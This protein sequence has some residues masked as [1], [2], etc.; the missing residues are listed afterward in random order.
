[1]IQLSNSNL[2]IIRNF[3]NYSNVFQGDYE[4]GYNPPLLTTIFYNLNF[5]NIIIII[6]ITII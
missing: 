1:M 5:N 6:I 3:N 2:H 4:G